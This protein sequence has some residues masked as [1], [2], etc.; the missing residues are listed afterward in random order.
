MT[1]VLNSRKKM[2]HLFVC[3]L[4]SASLVSCAEIKKNMDLRSRE[5][6]EVEPKECVLTRGMKISFANENGSGIIEYVSP[7]E[8]YIE[9]DIGWRGTIKC[10]P[11]PKPFRGEMGIYEPA[12]RSIGE[13]DEQN[14]R[15]IYSESNRYFSSREEVA[16]ALVGGSLRSQWVCNEGGYVVG[17]SSTFGVASITVYRYFLNGEVVEDLKEIMQESG[18]YLQSGEDKFVL[19]L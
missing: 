1:T 9:L 11:R 2:I 7:L 19:V 6:V 3:A 4:V 14:L 12:A 16:R 17:H 13:M 10:I 8:R 18:L 15:I 5:V